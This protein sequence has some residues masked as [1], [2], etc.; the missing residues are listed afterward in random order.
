MKILRVKDCPLCGKIIWKFY[1][2]PI[3]SKSNFGISINFRKL[4][5]EQNE[6]GTHFWILVN[7]SSRMMVA[8]CKDCLKK[9]TNE[10]VK[11]IFADIIYTKL[12]AIKKDKRKELHYKLFDRIRVIEVWRWGKTEKEIISYLQELKNEKINNTKQPE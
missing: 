3:I 8:I 12:E 7:D 5:H 4:P 6:D 11:Q 9:L 1:R 10:Q 2:P